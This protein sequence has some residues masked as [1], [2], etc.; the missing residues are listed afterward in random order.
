MN[1]ICIMRNYVLKWLKTFPFIC[2]HL[3]GIISS[4]KLNNLCIYV[5]KGGW[6]FLAWLI[7]LF[8]LMTVMIEDKWDFL[9]SPV[10]SL[11]GMYVLFNRIHAIEGAC[12]MG[13]SHYTSYYLYKSQWKQILCIS[14][15]NN[16][17][18]S[19]LLWGKVQWEWQDTYSLLRLA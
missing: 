3:A 13:Y 17:I 4:F 14:Y 12:T 19:P 1:S 5:N 15:T 11:H 2:E 16:I 18:F 7:V 6:S 10:Q 9:Q 8:Y